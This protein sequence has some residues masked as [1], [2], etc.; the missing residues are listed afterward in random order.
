[1]NISGSIR[2]LTNVFLVLFVI[3]SAG[4][5]YY[6]VAVAQQVTSN[7]SLAYTRQCTSD[8]A[9]IRGSIYDS[10]GVLLVYSKPNPDSELCGYRR[11]YTDAAKGLENLLGY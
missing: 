7:T 9:P 10:K 11:V 4:L 1:M 8:A 3:L 2:R 6:Q 5:V